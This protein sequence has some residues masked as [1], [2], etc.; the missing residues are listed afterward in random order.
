MRNQVKIVS[1]GIKRSKI[2]GKQIKLRKHETIW[3]VKPSVIC[4]IDK[5]VSVTKIKQSNSCNHLVE[6]LFVTYDNKKSV[7]L[8]SV[9]STNLTFKLVKWWKSKSACCFVCNF[10]KT[11]G[12]QPNFKIAFRHTPNPCHRDTLLFIRERGRVPRQ[13]PFKLEKLQNFARIRLK[14]I[15]SISR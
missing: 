5:E 3:F 8:F 12:V 15:Y 13:W 14:K 10:L 1:L 6:H 9:A 11:R 2:T 7:F 4:N